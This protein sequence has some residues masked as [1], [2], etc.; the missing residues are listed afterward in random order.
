[1]PHQPRPDNYDLSVKQ[2]SNLLRHLNQDPEILREYDSVIREQLRKGIVEMVEKPGEGE[3]GRTHY[4]PHHAVIRDKATTK[5]K[6]IN[7]ASA[8]SNGAALND[9][10]NTRPPLVGNIF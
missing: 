3:V 6:V 2:S 8:R 9:C 5:L 4:L 7:D 1:M 10:V